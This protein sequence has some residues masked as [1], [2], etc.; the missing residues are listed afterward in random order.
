MTR[1]LLRWPGCEP[2]RRSDGRADGGRVRVGAP[3]RR[4]PELYVAAGE[5]LVVAAQQVP[6]DLELLRDLQAANR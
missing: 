1:R 4:L 6:D 2:V 5:L 3:S